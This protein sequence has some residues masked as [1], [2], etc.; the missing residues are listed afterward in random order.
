MEL[1]LGNSFPL[2]LLVRKHNLPDINSAESIQYYQSSLSTWSDLTKVADLLRKYS[3]NDDELYAN[4]VLQ[5]T[6]QFLYKPTDNTKYPI[7]KFVEGS[8]DCD[9]PAVFAAAL[10]KAGELDSAIIYG[11]AKGSQEDQLGVGH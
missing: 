6:H 8:G 1:L 5:V 4:V 7:E 3:G 10:M 9:T 11:P 2:L